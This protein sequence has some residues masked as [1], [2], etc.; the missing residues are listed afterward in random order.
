MHAA[1]GVGLMGHPRLA[2]R[3]LLIT[4]STGIAAATA[5][6]ARAEDADVFIVSRD[7]EH[8]AA[9][10]DEVDGAWA[11]ADLTDEAAT[12]AAIGAAVQR[13]GRIDGCVAVA[14]GSGRP[15]GDGPLHALSAEGWDRTLELNLRSQALTARAVIRGMREQAPVGPQ[16]GSRGSVVLVSSVLAMHPV[17]EL[18]A[19]HAYAAAKGAIVSLA[20]ATAAAYAPDHIRVNVIAPGLTATPMAQRAADDPRTVA[21]VRRKQPLVDGFLGAEDIAG[22]AIY[23]L[24]DEARAVTG[25]VLSIDGGW[26]VTAAAPGP[27]A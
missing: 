22:G 16:P 4:G 2:G 15:L 17:P 27:A 12:D 11:A 20:I 25:Q 10:A 7:P 18:F 19:T 1:R 21:F 3:V 26:S 5:R 8:A 23:L 14:G 13:F 24:S 9:L 6:A